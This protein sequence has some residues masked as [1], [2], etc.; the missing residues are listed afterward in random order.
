M[1]VNIWDKP[2]LHSPALK[3]SQDEPKFITIDP[4]AVIKSSSLDKIRVQG[5]T[6]LEGDIAIS[7]A[8]NAALKHF[9]ATLLTGDAVQFTNAPVGLKDLQTLA[10]LLQEMGVKVGLREDGV[11][12]LQADNI[13]STK[14]PYDLVRQMRASVLVMEP[15]S[16]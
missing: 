11:A 7:G 15:W 4:Q 2:V 6:R 9:C 8:K 13:T 16:R 14:A 1:Q 3:L 10:A 12:I 5:G